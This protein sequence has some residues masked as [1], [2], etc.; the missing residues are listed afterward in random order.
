MRKAS[1]GRRPGE[2]VAQLTLLGWAI[3]GN[4]GKSKKKK[5]N[6][7]K[8]MDGIVE[9]LEKPNAVPKAR[10]LSTSDDESALE[11][12][13]DRKEEETIEKNQRTMIKEDLVPDCGNLQRLAREDKPLGCGAVCPAPEGGPSH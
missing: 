3:G 5:T 7:I 2:P 13:N 8:L 9:Q 10:T 6:C 1:G 12:N 4:T 11:K